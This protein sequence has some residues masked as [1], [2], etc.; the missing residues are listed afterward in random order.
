[1]IDVAII[2]GGPAGSAAAIACAQAGLATRLFERRARREAKDAIESIGP[3]C[4][5][6]LHALGAGFAGLV[7]PFAGIAT[8][9]TAATFGNGLTRAG[10]HLC[11]DGL[12]DALRRA[13]SEAGTDVRVGAEV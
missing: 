4:A 1:M 11:R 12:D 9:R 10:F 6:F 13:A 3:E 5:S 2:G 8:G 7:A